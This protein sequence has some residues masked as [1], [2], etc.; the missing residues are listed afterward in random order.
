MMT[1]Q[2]VFQATRPGFLILAPLCALLGILL[3]VHQPILLAPLEIVLVMVGGLLAHAAVNLLNEY[4]DFHSGLDQITQRTPF[5]GG[6]GALPAEPTAA[7][8]VLSAGVAALVG[9]VAIGGYFFWVRGWPVLAFGTIG[10]VLVVT[11]TRW[12]TRSAWLCLL[13]PGVGFGLAVTLGALIA[14]GGRVDLSALMVSVV[15]GLLVSEL[16][17]LN[18]FPDSEADR[19]IGRRHLP[20]AIGLHR[21]AWL[22][23]VMLLGS[24]AVTGLAV[25]T[26]WLPVAAML[27]WLT[28]PGALWLAWQLPGALKD[29]S[30]LEPLM[31]LN[32]V[33][34]LVTLA[35]LAAGLWLGWP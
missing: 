34:L 32:V 23:V 31:G 6:S 15:V 24:Y 29:R 21:A 11:Y 20:I 33:V 9:V 28:L 12:I 19:H 18:Q 10:L 5:S 13:A 17:L 4:E 14:L 25:L 22:V 2:T 3:A 1:M 16:L 35:L 7:P 30:R 27:S 26:G 8:A